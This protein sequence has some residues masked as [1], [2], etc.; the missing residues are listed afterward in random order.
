MSVFAV[1][2]FV[3]VIGNPISAPAQ[4]QPASAQKA[5]AA[6]SGVD[7]PIPDIPYTK[8]VLNNGL[9]VLVPRRLEE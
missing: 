1:L 6:V 5:P 9:T 7:I 3:M 2:A 8:F 4:S